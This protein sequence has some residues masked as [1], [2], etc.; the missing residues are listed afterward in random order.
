MK[1]ATTPLKH[2]ALVNGRIGWH[3]LSTDDYQDEGDYLVT[4]TD[5]S[6]GSITWSE[7]HRVTNGIWARDPM[8][9]LEHG[10][11]LV[12]KD[13]TIGKVALVSKP[14]GRATLNSGVFRVR[15]NRD[16]LDSRYLYW[17]LNSKLFTDF[18][19]LLSAGS[20]INHLYQRDF[21]NFQL[22]TPPKSI[23]RAIASYLDAETSRIDKL[24]EKK[25]RMVE[26]IQ[27]RIIVAA[28]QLTSS[29]NRWVP[30]RRVV[31][32]VKTGTTPAS[33]AYGSFDEITDGLEWVSPSDF[34]SRLTLRTPERFVSSDEVRLGSVPVFEAGSV[35]VVGVGA[36]TGKVVYSNRDLS[37]NQQVTALH[38]TPGNSGRFLAWNL[39][40][41]RQ[42]ILATVPFT[43]LPIL[44]N[45]FIRSVLVCNPPLDEQN[46]IVEFLDTLAEVVGNLEASIS[47]QIE[48]LTE[49]RQALITAAVTGQL[50]IPG[51]A[52]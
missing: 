25:Q 28:S 42:E 3:G 43:T 48:K 12:T 14:P 24:I 49:H 26:L 32:R 6:S 4:G 29:S 52:V 11:I 38:C 5:L 50:E 15:P 10:D 22:P 18:I 37:G 47:S 19:E 27:M 31:D 41:R 35:L 1:V 21:V 34:G 8:I 2:V 7:C 30:L 51:V 40:S 36:T 33:G 46:E 44:S 9:H 17:I 23:Q 13:G 16:E 39:W 45:D 20:T